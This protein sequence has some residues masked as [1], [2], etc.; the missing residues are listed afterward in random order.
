[1]PTAKPQTVS[2]ATYMSDKGP[3]WDRAVKKHGLKPNRYE[4]V[5]TWEFGDFI[6]HSD[7][8]VLLADTK[9]FRHGFTKTVDT[10]ERALE[11]L[12]RFREERIIP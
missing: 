10:E 12:R 7:W 4:D 9:R 2:L 6:F 8:D 1:M 3:V 5:A 11:T